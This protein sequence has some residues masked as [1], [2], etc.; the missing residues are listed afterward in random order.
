MR[1]QTYARP[2]LTKGPQTSAPRITTSAVIGNSDRPSKDF[3]LRVCG[4]LVMAMPVGRAGGDRSERTKDT[5]RIGDG[6]RRTQ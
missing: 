6:A 1:H 2:K 5:L 3:K 4:G